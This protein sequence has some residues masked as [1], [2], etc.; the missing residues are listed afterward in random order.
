MQ[1]FAQQ[2]DIFDPTLAKPVTVV[3]VGS[4]GSQLVC[5]LAKVG[6]TD[7]T[8]WDGDDVASHNIPMSA[9]RLR[10]L[11]R[12]KVM[13]LRDIVFDASGVEI[14][15][16]QEMYAGQKLK[17][18]VV[19]CVDSMEARMAIWNAV[20]GKAT[21]DVFVDTRIGAEL[22]EVYRVN[23]CNPLEA[24][25]YEAV[26]YPSSKAVAP[27]CGH[28]GIIYVTATAAAAA[29]SR[30]TATWSGRRTDWLFRELVGSLKVA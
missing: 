10:D 26:L 25:D 22:V 28:H 4:V 3:G 1:N 18:S 27:Q 30:L 8:V 16:R 21:A 20:K 19:S 11:C 6:C 12:P 15:V 9:Y 7:I 5:M 17:G 14:K 2:D 29:C 24:E 23:P 13:A